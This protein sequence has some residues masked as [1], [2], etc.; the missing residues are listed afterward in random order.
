MKTILTFSIIWLTNIEIIVYFIDN[1]WSYC[2]I[3]LQAVIIYI[4]NILGAAK[5]PSTR[6]AARVPSTRERSHPALAGVYSVF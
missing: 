5:V 2:V 6:G 3:K 1:E 4:Q